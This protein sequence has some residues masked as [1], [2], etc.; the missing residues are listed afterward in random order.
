MSKNK[1][2]Y[3]WRDNP[4]PEGSK[5]NEIWYSAFVH[6]LNS[7][8][9]SLALLLEEAHHALIEISAKDNK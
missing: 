9:K 5:E 7:A 8:T 3:T 1:L 2:T 6:G 4:Y